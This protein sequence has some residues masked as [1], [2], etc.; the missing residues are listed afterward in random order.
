MKR[1]VVLLSAGALAAAC[2][3]VDADDLFTPGGHGGAGGGTAASGTSSSGVAIGSSSGS[4]TTSSSS[5]TT[6][7][8][9]SSTSA[10][11]SSSTTS[12]SS[13]GTPVAV[14]CNGG[15]CNP[16]EIC[17]F[18]PQGPGDHCAQPGQCDQ[19]WVT[20]TC[21]GPEDCPGGACCATVDYNKQVPYLGISCQPACSPDQLVMC[22]EAQPGVCPGGLSCRQSMVLGAGYR[23][24]GN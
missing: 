18:N 7:T 22:S 4:G 3:G 19:G 23:Y 21:N 14:A 12:S 13:S 20:I 1:L 9:S 5:S 16:G 24:C 15:P 17:C 11:S 2:G 8:S 10:S 6:T